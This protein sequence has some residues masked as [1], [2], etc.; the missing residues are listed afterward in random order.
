MAAAGTPRQAPAPAPSISQTTTG[1]VANSTGHALN[2]AIA[3]ADNAPARSAIAA[4]FHPQD[5]M[6]ARPTARNLLAE[7]TASR[8]LRRAPD[9][10][11]HWPAWDLAPAMFRGGGL[12]AAHAP[13]DH[14][15]A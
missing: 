11:C 4:R 13:A 2:G 12:R 15:F 9:W 10:H 5:R 8:L 3:S 6:I 14:P 1:K 7:I